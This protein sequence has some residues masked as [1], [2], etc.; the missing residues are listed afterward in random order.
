M[1]AASGYSVSRHTREFVTCISLNK[2]DLLM[3]H[4]IRFI[5]FSLIFTGVNV[6]LFCSGEWSMGTGALK[7]AGQVC[8]YVC[9]RLVDEELACTYVCASRY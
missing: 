1:S 2:S 3:I 4:F 8:T 5:L 9:E 6:L 7:Q